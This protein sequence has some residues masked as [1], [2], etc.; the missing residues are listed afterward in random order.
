M[1][2]RHIAVLA[3]LAAPTMSQTGVWRELDFPTSPSGRYGVAIVYDSARDRVVMVGGT[4]NN[5]S[6]AFRETWENDGLQWSLRSTGGPRGSMVW[7]PQA[8]L[9]A[10]YDS[11]RQ[12]TVVV[13]SNPSNNSTDTWEW[14]GSAWQLRATGTVPPGRTGCAMAFDSNRGVTVLFGGKSNNTGHLSDTWEWDGASWLQRGSGGPA[15]RQLHGMAF[16]TV[17]GKTVLFGGRMD[18]SPYQTY[19]DTWEWNG[20]YWVEH[21][22]VSGPPQRWAHAMTF[23]ATRGVTLLQGGHDPG[24]GGGNYYDTWEWNESQ[25]V[26]RANGLAVGRWPA[27]C[28]DAQR[29]RTVMFGGQDHYGA[30]FDRTRAFAV[31]ANAATSTSFGMGCPGPNGVPTLTAQ[32][33]PRLGTTHSLLLSNLPTGLLS[34]PMGCI[35]FDNTQ[36]NNIPLPASLDPLG[37]T[38]CTALLA[39]E[40][41]Y[42][43][44][45][46]LGSAT[47]QVP[48]PFLPAFSGLTFHAQAAVLA[49]GVN[50][51]GI[52]FTNGVTSVIGY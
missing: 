14:D 43:L 19:G 35:G 9:A 48:V 41:T 49:P 52:V 2:M 4:N 20:L 15:P 13:Q 8:F 17:R 3:L 37:F 50:P 44:Q 39:P 30:I 45:N 5:G 11:L 40:G 42:V 27:M 29:Q 12:R 46:T 22:G 33:T 51:G 31:I 23:D 1:E 25:W 6:S 32:N 36:W 7:Y 34:L 16:D 18:T 38:G 26:Q 28:H 47:W 10:A 24:A 21:F